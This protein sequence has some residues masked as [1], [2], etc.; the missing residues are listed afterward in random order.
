[1]HFYVSLLRIH[2]NWYILNLL[3]VHQYCFGFF[4]KF[5]IW[6]IY[7][8]IQ[9][10]SS[11]SR[12]IGIRTTFP[13]AELFRVGAASVS[14]KISQVKPFIVLC[15]YMEIWTVFLWLSAIGLPSVVKYR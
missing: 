9:M 12:D 11:L 1:M 4:A 15:F 7:C 14:L 6:I 3:N 10:S 13:E 8:Q 2:R 5:I